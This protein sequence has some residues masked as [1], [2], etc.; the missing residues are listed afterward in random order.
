MKTKKNHEGYL[1]IDHRNSPGIPKEFQLLGVPQELIV[2]AGQILEIAIATCSHCQ[3][4]IILNP[5]RT[6]PRNNC[7]KCD[8]YIC[9]KPECNIECKPIKKLIDEYLEQG[10]RN[11][12]LSEI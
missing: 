12:N 7:P 10:A 3:A 9:D 2:G 6:R 11:L 8:H 5:S 4:E 1:L